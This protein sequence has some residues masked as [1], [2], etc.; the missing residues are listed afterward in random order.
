[1]AVF[2]G[3][4]GADAIYKALRRICIVLSKYNVKLKSSLELA[5]NTGIIT[6]EQ[7]GTALTFING[8]VAACEVFRVVSDWSGLG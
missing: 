2:T 4:I 6:N 7:Y 3:K 8:A 1:M 5:K